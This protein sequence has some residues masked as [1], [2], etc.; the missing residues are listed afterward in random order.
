M[1]AGQYRIPSEEQPENDLTNGQMGFL[2]HLDE[3]RTR[4]IRSCCVIAAGM[5]VA[6]LFVDRITDFVLEAAL[7]TLPVGSSL[8]MTK[9]GEGLALYLDLALMGG[10]VL[11]A[12]FVTYQVW[13]F[14][15]PGLYAKERR[16]VIPFVVLATLG[17]L[18]GA[19]FSHY[20]LFPSMMAFFS[21][22]DSPRMRFMP[23]VEDTFDLYRNTLIGMVAVFQIPTLVF[24]LARMRLVTARLLWR[25][26]KYAV[27]VIFI[28]A[29]M[30]TPSPDPW[31]QTVFAAPMMALYVISIGI[32]WL[33]RPRREP[34]SSDP[35][36]KL[37]FAAAVIDRASRRR[38]PS[39]EFPRLWQRSE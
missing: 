19:A 33:V 39:G 17:T 27:L 14:V 24:F 9:P 34:E 4:L 29:A 10:V 23:R 18:A 15:A 3:L 13:R 7:R 35:A 1:A 25:H 20:V 32:A 5:I 2:E 31:N 28:A 36:L 8:I 16:F 11:A 22:F 38:A 6:C 26:I 37:V 21:R 30:L 12:P